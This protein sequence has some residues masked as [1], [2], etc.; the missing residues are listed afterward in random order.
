MF[1]N[2]KISMT[3]ENACVCKVAVRLL[4][5]V[6]RDKQGSSQSGGRKGWGVCVVSTTSSHGQGKVI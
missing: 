2:K 4:M 1:C 6:S 3:H 5:F